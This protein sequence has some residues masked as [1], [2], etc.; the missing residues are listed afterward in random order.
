LPSRGIDL[1]Q[2]KENRAMSATQEPHKVFEHPSEVVADTSLTRQ[3]KIVALNS[4]EQDARQLATAS[5]EGMSG[6]EDTALREVLLA[7]NTL[8][9]PAAEVA[10]AVVLQSFEAK[11]AQAEGTDGHA[12]IGRAIEAIKAALQAIDGMEELP[13]GAPEPG[14]KK[15]LEEELAKEKLDP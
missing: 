8:D 4:L 10:V 11:L 6:G 1:A 2:R 3:E 12:V 15:D 13:S 5:G 14:S 9:L 7:R